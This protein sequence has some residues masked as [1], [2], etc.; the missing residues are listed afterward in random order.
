[1]A[2][3]LD[4][5]T[6]DQLAAAISKAIKNSGGRYDD[7][8]ELNARTPAQRAADVKKADQAQKTLIKVM[9]S[10][11]K[12][13]DTQGK[14]VR[15]LED[16][17]KA[18]TAGNKKVADTFKGNFEK[19]EREL[20][21]ALNEAVTANQGA[22]ADI[23]KLAG[24][25]D[26]L[27][28]VF[29]FDDLTKLMAE[30]SEGIEG[31]K[32]H[33]TSAKATFDRL[34]KL[35]EQLDKKDS[36]LEKIDPL[37]KD[38]DK[39]IDELTDLN[40]QTKE[41]TIKAGKEGDVG[42]T[43]QDWFKN[44][45]VSPDAQKKF[46]DL[47]LNTV[48]INADK[49][50]RALSANTGILSLV[51][52]RLTGFAEK[53]FSAANALSLLEKA[54]IQIYKQ[55]KE[56]Y[57]TGTEKGFGAVIARDAASLWHG[58]DPNVVQQ[59]EKTNAQ[60]R[61]NMGRRNY[62]SAVYGNINDATGVTGDRND[63]LKLEGNLMTS[64]S[65]A[66]V[67]FKQS[68][69]VADGLNLQFAQLQYLTGTTA[70]EF[71]Q[72]NDQLLGDADFRREMLS[73]NDKQRAAAVE[74]INQ[75]VVEN[76]L[77]GYSIDQTKQQIDL[78]RKLFD[79][80][81]PKKRLQNRTKEQ[82]FL[83]TQGVNNQDARDIATMHSVGGPEKYEAQLATTLGPERARARVNQ[84]TQTVQGVAVKAQNSL[85][86]DTPQALYE[87][88]LIHGTGM[89]AYTS[90]AFIPGQK[91]D[92]EARADFNKSV[93]TFDDAVNKFSGSILSTVDRGKAI[94]TSAIGMAA[95]AGVVLLVTK[96]LGLAGKAL[97]IV[98][99]LGGPGGKA[100]IG[101][102]I[103]AATGWFGKGAKAVGGAAGAMGPEIELV[104]GIPRA[105]AAASAASGLKD[106]SLLKAA[107]TAGK[108]GKGLIKGLPGLA[109]A[110][111][112][113]V[114]P[115]KSGVGKVLNSNTVNGALLGSTLGS[116]VPGLGTAIGGAAGGVIGAGL[117]AY[118]Y[119]ST[120]DAKKGSKT[121]TPT[122]R[123]EPDN[124]NNPPLPVNMSD[125]D[126]K[127]M[128]TDALGGV[129]KSDPQ[130]DQVKLLQDANATLSKILASM[131][132]QTDSLNQNGDKS[133]DA[134]KR[135][136]RALKSPVGGADSD[137][138]AAAKYN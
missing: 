60:S 124:D 21:K 11:A 5:A 31:S 68:A 16:A 49:S 107:T 72:L 4:K 103:S 123:S 10:L 34:M 90:D 17:L 15:D 26:K 110:G 114:V 136:Q 131:Q 115:E 27:E 35:Y 97:E 79:P 3:S 14:T 83:S 75:M 66:G 23:R 128:S 122:V 119:F 41:R 96:R 50:S 67:S 19:T 135:L 57:G 98:K 80:L 121:P 37:L 64:V 138:A 65:R 89:D 40:T 63:A 113:M 33:Q 108:I 133:L 38:F 2:D 101:A 9:M 134:L 109:I 20:V 39:L 88:G 91:A 105:K 22:G 104:N 42:K 46:Q 82:I 126:F 116:F 12:A 74:N 73:L 6:I 28:D 54:A 120:P 52:E 61:A 47:G 81:D 43:V 99:G 125:A 127:N 30:I 137:L 77:R 69:K 78:F 58:V 36:S 102:G 76:S 56:A 59:V 132:D 45:K 85:S 70:E 100:A 24:N 32:T 55:T 44:N 25:I 13:Q 93:G 86:Q 129:R 106:F 94:G 51:G 95:M 118:D 84:L 53:T 8:V 62:N 130:A 18:S 117:D 7:Q 48:A 112:Q 111:A 71:S 87:Q 1:M 92:G 29:R